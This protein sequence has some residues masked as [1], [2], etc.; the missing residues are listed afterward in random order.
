MFA[1]QKRPVK[2]P[3][4]EF[5]Y[6]K[7]SPQNFTQQFYCPQSQTPKLVEHKFDIRK[8]KNILTNSKFFL[9]KN[10]SIEMQKISTSSQN[11]IYT[12]QTHDY[13]SFH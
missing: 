4:E 8:T 10:F 3:A 6:S 2:N 11:V 7:K 1:I 9:F 5:Y 13:T 12:L